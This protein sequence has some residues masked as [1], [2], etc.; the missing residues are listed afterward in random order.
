[1]LSPEVAQ[2]ILV[3]LLPP[4]PS[5]RRPGRFAAGPVSRSFRESVA[6]VGESVGA[7][8]DDVAPYVRRS[9]ITAQGVGE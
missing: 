5:R 9:T 4:S 1:M 6:G 3:S 8:L 7:G 2:P